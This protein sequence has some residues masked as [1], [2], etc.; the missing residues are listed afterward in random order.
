MPRETKTDAIPS[1]VTYGRHTQPG[2]LVVELAEANALCGRLAEQLERVVGERNAAREELVQANLDVAALRADRDRVLAD[3][4]TLARDVEAVRR[5]QAAAVA[6]C[7]RLLD[8]ARTPPP[9]TVA[10]ALG[11]LRALAP[12]DAATAVAA[13]LHVLVEK[14][15]GALT[16]IVKR[17]GGARQATARLED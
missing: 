5:E 3:G 4:K 15:V 11:Q 12:E 10:T 16:E 1:A 17:R 7:R 14:P 6:E 9:P 8:A 2:Y 13:W